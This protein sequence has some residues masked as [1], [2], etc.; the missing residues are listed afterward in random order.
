M[1]KTLLPLKIYPKMIDKNKMKLK[2]YYKLSYTNAIAL[3]NAIDYF[4][5]YLTRKYKKIASDGT[6]TLQ[7]L[8]I[9]PNEIQKES[10][11]LNYCNHQ[12]VVSMEQYCKEEVKHA[13]FQLEVVTNMTDM[14]LI[15]HPTNV[16]KSLEIPEVQIHLKAITDEKNFLIP[17]SGGCYVKDVV[18]YLWEMVYENGEVTEAYLG[19]DKQKLDILGISYKLRRAYYAGINH[20][21][22]PVRKEEVPRLL[23]ISTDL[24]EIYTHSFVDQR[25]RETSCEKKY[26]YK[27]N[28]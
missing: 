5:D 11:G 28:S 23:D 12:L 4:G 14:L 21:L 22:L 26:Q 19:M 6:P 20:G 15:A 13:V 18:R 27:R 8:F 2:D 24:Y 16:E 10:N 9:A 1:S 3:W 17:D 7:L 25:I